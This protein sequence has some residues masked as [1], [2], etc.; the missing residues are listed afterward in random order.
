VERAWEILTPV[1]DLPGAPLPY[2]PGTW[3]P[4]AADALIAPRS[5]HVSAAPPA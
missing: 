1:L 5:W 4:A 3:G 2:E